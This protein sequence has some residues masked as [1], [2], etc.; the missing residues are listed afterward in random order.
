MNGWPARSAASRKTHPKHIHPGRGAF[1]A[2]AV[3]AAGEMR[4]NGSKRRGQRALYHA[5]LRL[6]WSRARTPALVGFRLRFASQKRAAGRWPHRGQ[7]ARYHAKLRLP[8]PRARTPALVGFRL[9]FAPQKRAAG[10]RPRLLGLPRKIRRGISLRETTL[11]GCPLR[12]HDFVTPHRCFGLPHFRFAQAWPRGQNPGARRL[13]P[14]FCS[15]KTR[16]RSSAPPFG[17]AAQNQARHF[18]ARNHP[19][20]LSASRP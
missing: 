6:P 8:W 17:F 13:P 5:K 12:G 3:F 10:H 1:C 18:A 7:R 16:G 14:P 19:V 4:L 2:P 11:C 20:R 9:R 15:A